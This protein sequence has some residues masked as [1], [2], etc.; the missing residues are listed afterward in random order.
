MKYL[1]A[2]TASIALAFSAAA[3]DEDAETKVWSGEGSLSAGVTTGNTDTIDIGVGAKAK[4]EEGR[5]TVAVE[6][7]YDYGEIDGL[8]SRDRWFVSGQTDYDLTER[9]YTFARVSY[10]QDD[11]SGFDSRLFSGVGAGYHIF[12]G[13]RFTWSVEASPGFRISEVSDELDPVTGAIVVPGETVTNFAVRGGSSLKYIFN[14]NVDFT[15]QTN[16]V[17]TDLST[18]TIN[19]SALNAKLIGALTARLS[20]EVRNDTNPPIGFVETDTATRLSL[21]YGF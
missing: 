3:Q 10:E 7:A 8:A 9:I 21:V 14:E 2:A 18:Q 16:V 19:M 4:R 6:G 5:W 1:L 20:F 13:D 12:K 11:F 17:W 15:N